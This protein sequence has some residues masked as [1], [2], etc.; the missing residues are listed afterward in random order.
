[1]IEFALKVSSTYASRF[2]FPSF[3]FFNFKTLGIDFCDGENIVFL[4]QT[5]NVIPT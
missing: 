1:M 2:K 4:V 5:Q 3:C